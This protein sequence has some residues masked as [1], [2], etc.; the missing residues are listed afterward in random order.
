MKPR[1]A[2][3]PK[4]Y[5]DDLCV[6]HTISEVSTCESGG[7]FRPFPPSRAGRLRVNPP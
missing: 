5:M 3:F 4:C 2:A 7:H 1:L 6:H